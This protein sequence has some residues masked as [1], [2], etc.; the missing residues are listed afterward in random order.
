[1]CVNKHLKQK[2]K[3][4]QIVVKEE[5]TLTVELLTFQLRNHSKTLNY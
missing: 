5:I 2:S 1:L 4:R 3:H